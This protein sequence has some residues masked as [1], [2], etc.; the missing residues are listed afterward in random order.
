LQSFRL[1]PRR[2]LARKEIPTGC[3]MTNDNPTDGLLSTAE[4][5]KRLKVSPQAVSK[6]TKAG[7]PVAKRTKSTHGKPVMFFDLRAVRTWLVASGNTTRSMLA[8]PEA[9]AVPADVPKVEATPTEAPPDT[10][11]AGSNFLAALTRARDSEAATFAL[12]AKTL[13]SDPL[14]AA[15]HHARWIAAADC[16]LRLEKEKGKIL[17]AE[18][19]MMKTED[20]YQATAAIFQAVRIDLEA[21]PNATAPRLAGLSVPEVA[22]LL[23]EAVQDTLRHLHEGKTK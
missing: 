1:S 15:A 12:W 4:L 8:A 18:G 20:A 17:L 3:F 10:S 6:W 23:R 16:L 5:A 19:A 21:L 7:C 11:P 22:A 14:A 9:I 13:K 2:L